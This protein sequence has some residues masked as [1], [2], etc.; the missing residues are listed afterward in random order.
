VDGGG[1]PKWRLDVEG[2]TVTSQALSHLRI[3]DLTH[4]VAGPYCTKLFSGFGADVLKVERVGMGDPLRSVGPFFEQKANLETSI[5]FLWLNTGKKSITLNLKDKHGREIL[6]RLI[7]RVDAL[8]ENFSPRVMP[9]LGLDYETL[10]EIN[11]RLVMTSISNFGQSGPYRNYRA[12]EIVE[13]ALSGLM[14]LTGDPAKAPLASGPSMAQ[15]TAGLSAYIATL[16]ALFQRAARGTGQ[17]VDV[18]IQEACLDNIEIAM[19]E[20]LHRGIIAK[21]RK[22]RHALV[23]WEL[24]PC[25]DGYAAIIGGPVRH[26]LPAVDLFE[27]PRLAEQRYAHMADRIA[28]RD[29]VETLLQ[30]WVGQRKKKDIYRAGQA[31]RLA[32]GYL[33]SPGDV[34]ESPQHRARGYFVDVDHPV[35]GRHSCCGAPFQM[36]ETPWRSMRAPLLGEHNEDVYSDTLT[37]DAIERLKSEGVI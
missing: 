4:Y 9:S 5:P 25:Q 36:G 29:E 6:K 33:A 3:L 8:V 22:D 1:S 19:A 27:E 17:H 23:P 12:Q 2:S 31:R 10:R 18:S 14:Y 11:P 15:Y 32:F 26:W 34:L 30:R 28:R 7:E 37:Q 35:V 21:R 16:M 24:Y 13:Y 20:Y